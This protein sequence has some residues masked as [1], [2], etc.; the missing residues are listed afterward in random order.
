M[1]C[2]QSSKPNESRTGPQGFIFDPPRLVARRNQ[3]SLIFFWTAIPEHPR[4]DR[5]TDTI[6]MWVIPTPEKS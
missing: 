4:V 5:N 2:G 6:G 3:A 1:E